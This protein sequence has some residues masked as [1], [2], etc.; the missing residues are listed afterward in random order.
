[1]PR[2]IRSLRFA[3]V[4]ACFFLSW[5]AC[6]EEIEF[7]AFVQADY[8]LRDDLHAWRNTAAVLGTIVR[9]RFGSSIAPVIRVNHPPEGFVALLQ[10]PAKKSG[11]LRVLYLAS[12]VEAD[13]TILFSNR[14]KM[15]PGDL[16]ARLDGR[17]GFWSP[18]VVIA[19]TCHAASFA[20]DRRWLGTVE[21]DHLFSSDTNQLSWELDMTKKKVIHLAKAYPRV[22]AYLE[23]GLGAD[24]DGKVSDLGFRAAKLHV[25]AGPGAGSH[26]SGFR[27]WLQELAEVPKEDVTSR[28][29]RQ[30][31]IIWR[32]ADQLR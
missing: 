25:H 23:N 4:A 7:R 27:R 5:R 19:D 9:E 21:A 18:D 31:N 24:W 20:Y 11:A 14:T 16:A 26:G 12:H 30:S 1:M 28:R 3:L 13:G 2:P 8:R 15:L 22:F 29:F 10:M 17:S 6:G 32:S